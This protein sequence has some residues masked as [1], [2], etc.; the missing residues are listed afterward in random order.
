PDNLFE[1]SEPTAAVFDGPRNTCPACF[2]LSAL[3]CEIV[4]TNPFEIMRTRFVGLVLFKPRANLVSES[5]L[6]AREVQVDHGTLQNRNL[7]DDCV[8]NYNCCQNCLTF[9]RATGLSLPARSIKIH[10]SST[11]KPLR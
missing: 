6:L 10:K 11:R 8:R 1:Q 9:Q 2:V 7:S 4:F 3:P 5:A